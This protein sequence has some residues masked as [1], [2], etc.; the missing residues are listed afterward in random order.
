MQINT[1]EYNT[2]PF[3]ME[4]L[5]QIGV[6]SIVLKFYI[7]IEYIE[8]ELKTRIAGPNRSGL[9]V[10]R[11][12]YILCLWFWI[13]LKFGLLFLDPKSSQLIIYVIFVCSKSGQGSVT[14]V[15]TI[16]L[17]QTPPEVLML[18]FILSVTKH[19]DNHLKHSLI[20]YSMCN[21]LLNI[22]YLL[23][24]CAFQLLSRTYC[25]FLLIFIIAL[26]HALKTLLIAMLLLHW[27]TISFFF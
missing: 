23:H 20:I 25:I 12:W 26:Q 3:K 1:I 7:I 18:H 4:L 22:A 16:A 5:L 19:I 10:F 8:S 6:L 2:L 27:L 11:I 15:S 21:K 14:D 24:R 9:N 17:S 13:H